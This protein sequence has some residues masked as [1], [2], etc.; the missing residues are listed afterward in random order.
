MA[1]KITPTDQERT[2]DG[3]PPGPASIMDICLPKRRMK[4]LQHNRSSISQQRSIQTL[5]DRLQRQHE[6]LYEYSRGLLAKINTLHDHEA[7]IKKASYSKYEPLP[8]ETT[9]INTFIENLRHVVNEY[10]DMMKCKRFSL[11]DHFTLYELLVKTKIEMQN[12]AE[13]NRKLQSY[14]EDAVKALNRTTSASMNT[15]LESDSKESYTPLKI[16]HDGKSICSICLAVQK[17]SDIVWLNNC[18]HQFCLNCVSVQLVLTTGRHTCAVCREH[19]CLYSMLAK[20]GQTYYIQAMYKS[21]LLD[22]YQK[23]TLE[24]MLAPV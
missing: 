19:S 13:Q 10:E 9:S 3:Q 5:K 1:A 12:M 14:V 24:N 7:R 8:G 20:K 21:Q 6:D 15:A 18:P 2:Q 23:R 11:D 16:L 4:I 17:F 22:E